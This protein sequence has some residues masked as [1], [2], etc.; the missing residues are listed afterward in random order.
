M[1]SHKAYL[2]DAA[3]GINRLLGGHAFLVIEGVDDNKYIIERIEII[4]QQQ[5]LIPP[6]LP[7]NIL[8]SALYFLGIF[9]QKPTVS[10]PD[11]FVSNIICH[12]VIANIENGNLLID[13]EVKEKLKSWNTQNYETYNL[14]SDQFKSLRRSFR[15]EQIKFAH[16]HAEAIS[17]IQTNEELRSQFSSCFVSSL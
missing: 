5:K 10:A 8:K 13:D 17:L 11:G 15:I 7:L 2:V 12:S 14:D 6:I 3:K 9:S 4:A 1:T 16:A